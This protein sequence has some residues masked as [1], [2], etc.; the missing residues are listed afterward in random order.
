MSTG[1]ALNDDVQPELIKRAAAKMPPRAQIILATD[2]DPAGWKLSARLQALISPV[3]AEECV[4]SVQMPQ[5]A[6]YGLLWAKIHPSPVFD[7]WPALYAE[8]W[9]SPLAILGRAGTVS[10]KFAKDSLIPSK[11]L[12]KRTVYSALFGLLELIGIPRNIGPPSSHSRM[13]KLEAE[14]S[15][16]G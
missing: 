4:V 2:N 3:L 5:R 8:D 7:Q 9:L 1:G 13:C 10:T 12:L 6:F 11:K 15:L 14:I 16:V